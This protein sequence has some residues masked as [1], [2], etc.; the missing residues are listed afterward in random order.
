VTV[1]SAN[2][3]RASLKSSPRFRSVHS[4]FAGSLVM[5]TGLRNYG[6]G[7]GQGNTPLPSSSRFARQIEPLKRA[8]LGILDRNGSVAAERVA[9]VP[10]VAGHRPGSDENNKENAGQQ[11]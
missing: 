9:P 4:R 10:N 6:N 5:R 7:G 2:T 11:D 8:G 1:G 3:S